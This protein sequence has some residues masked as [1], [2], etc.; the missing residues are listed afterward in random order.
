MPGA[1]HNIHIAI[2]TPAMA[3]KRKAYT[4]ITNLQGVK[5]AEKMSKEAAT[6]LANNSQLHVTVS[7]ATNTMN[8]P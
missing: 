2:I 3:T 4:V 7:T 8:M 6:M 5:V 1:W